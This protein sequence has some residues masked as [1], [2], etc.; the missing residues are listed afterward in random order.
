MVRSCAAP[1]RYRRGSSTGYDRQSVRSGNGECVTR[2]ALTVDPEY[3]K[4]MTWALVA[5]ILALLLSFGM[6]EWVV[7]RYGP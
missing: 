4:M 5:L 7:R 2:R 3:R 6:V 1:H